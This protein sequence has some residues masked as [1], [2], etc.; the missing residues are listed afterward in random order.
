MPCPNPGS[1]PEGEHSQAEAASL[2]PAELLD[3][4]RR[5]DLADLRCAVRDW[6]HLHA[7]IAALTRQADVLQRRILQLT[8]EEEGGLCLDWPLAVGP[9]LIHSRDGKLT[10]SSY[11]PI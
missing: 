2:T 6:L 1:A 11:T 7:Q 8:D 10:V 3:L 9:N 5:N 4:E